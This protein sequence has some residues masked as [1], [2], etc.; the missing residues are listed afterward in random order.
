[1][2]PIFG[3]RVWVWLLLF[4]FLGFP[5][6]VL[7]A[8]KTSPTREVRRV[9]VIAFAA[10]FLKSYE[11]LRS[12]LQA[13][14]YKLDEELIFSVHSIERDT[15]KV[16]PLVK[17]IVA[18]NFDLI[19]TITTSVTQA[20]KNCIDENRLDIPVVFTVVADPVGSNI[21]ASLRHPHSNF[22]GISHVSKEL[23]P[24]RL[25]IFKKAF[26]KIKRMAV[27]FDP[28][29]EISMSSFNQR[30]IHQAAQDQGVA[31]VVK[32]VSNLAEMQSTC[33]G[34]TTADIDS[35]FMLP[36]ALSVAYFDEFLNLSQR[37]QIPLMVIDNMLLRRGGVIGYSPDFY[38]VGVQAATVVNQILKGV[39]VGDIAVQNPE[40]VRLV[41]SLKE[42]QALNLEVDEDILLQADEVLR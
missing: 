35:V 19:F 25:L 42:V 3:L 36:D 34:L 38:D 41:I 28:G 27:F 30:Y 5:G 4:S 26:P 1:M 40:K 33:L 32:H 9:A 10:P 7:S 12:G 39:L 15:T 8:T 17:K 18:S 6:N 14:G 20:V 2:S 11:G 37:L 22:T 24:Q 16:A 21:V 29:E 23:L 31:M 13:Q